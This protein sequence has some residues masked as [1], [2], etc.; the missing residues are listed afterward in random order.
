MATIE[1][2]RGAALRRGLIVEAA[3]VLWMIV[4]AVVAI[5]AGLAAR[6][7]ASV[8]FGLDSVVE[9]IAAGVLISRLQAEAGGRERSEVER[10]ERVSGRIVG[11]IL[12]LLA[13]FVVA[14][15]L[16]TLIFRIEPSPSPLAIGLAVAALVVM[17]I[18]VRIK[19]RVADAIDSP[20]LRGDAACGITC[21]YMAATLLVG[22]ALNALFGWWWA[23]PLA[24]LAIVYFLVREASEA[25]KGE[26]CDGSGC[27]C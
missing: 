12:Y 5:G 2:S 6:S 23:D 19:R 24:A 3:S 8:A 17:P 4:E 25:W 27:G 9:L 14:E 22:L 16:A 18:L 13:A 10:V 20:A 26:C 7:G 21:A 11:A 15:S 1:R